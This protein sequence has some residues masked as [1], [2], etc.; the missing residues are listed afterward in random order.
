MEPYSALRVLDKVYQF[1]GRPFV[2]ERLRELL[3]ARRTDRQTYNE[4]EP[5]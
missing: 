3:Y 4:S 2:V 5:W 1:L